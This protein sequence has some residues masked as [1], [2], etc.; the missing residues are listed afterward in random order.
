MTVINESGL[1]SLILSSKLSSAKKFKRCVTSEVLPSIRKIGIYTYSEEPIS[2]FHNVTYE[3]MQNWKYKI[4][5]PLMNKVSIILHKDTRTT[6]DIIYSTMEGIGDGSFYKSSALADFITADDIPCNIINAIAQNDCYK[7]L[8]LLA[9]KSIVDDNA[10]R[11][12]EYAN[13]VTKVID[14]IMLECTESEV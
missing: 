9:V 11:A 12:A 1:Y 13:T 8:Y 4:A 2:E 7:N 3:K 5:Y 10:S 6:L 14:K